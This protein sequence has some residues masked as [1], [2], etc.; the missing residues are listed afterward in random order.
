MSLL[1]LVAMM[2]PPRPEVATAVQTCRQAGIRIVMITGDYAKTARSIALQAGLAD[3]DVLTGPDLERLDDVQLAERLRTVTICARIMP[4]QK[5]RIVEALKSAGEIVAMTGDGVNDAPSLKSAHI[6][7][8][9]GKRGTD[10][11]REAAAIVLL[12]DDF[13]SIVKAIALGRRIYG[14]IRKAMAFIFAVHVPIAGFALIPLLLGM[15]IL[16]GP[17]HIALLEMVIDPVCAFV[18][19]AEEAEPDSMQRPP[20]PPA[21]RLF[22]WGM[23]GWSVFQGGLAFALLTG[24]Y[25]VAMIQGLDIGHVRTL[26]FFAL[27]SA[28]VALVLSDR[29]ASMSIAATLRRKN[30]ALAVVLASVVTISA[31]IMLIPGISKLLRFSTLNWQDWAVTL[32]VGTLLFLL[33][34]AVKA[35]TFRRAIF[36]TDRS[37]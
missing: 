35:L 10:V 24:V 31:A 30:A 37:L 3:G 26:L 5:L 4:E 25:A 29:S 20:R 36:P 16:F 7:I 22:S 33:F 1:G 21:E 2:D 14:N 17:I 13:G 15:P 19:E 9:M 6:G 8:A 12:D 32:C 23:I 34:Q 11:A 18:F 27:I 28:I